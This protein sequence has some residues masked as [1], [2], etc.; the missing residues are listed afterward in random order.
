M[1][2]ALLAAVMVACTQGPKEEAPKA[3]T[4]SPPQSEH[5][6]GTQ[7][8]SLSTAQTPVLVRT[9]ATQTALADGRVLLAGGTTHGSPGGTRQA[10]LFTY[11]SPS[12]TWTAT[13]QM[14]VG[15]YDHAA[16]RLQ[17]GRVLVSGGITAN[18]DW[19]SAELFT[20]TSGQW[21]PVASMGTARARH[22]Q[23]LLANGKVL[24]IGGDNPTTAQ[25]LASAELFDP[26]TG[27]WTATAAPSFAYSSHS[28]TLLPDGRVLVLGNRK[29][30]EL[31]N[32]STNTW[33]RTANSP[34]TLSAGHTATVRASPNV[35]VVV[36]GANWNNGG[37]VPLA[38]RYLPGNNV[39]FT[40]SNPSVARKGHQAVML[41]NG[42]VRIVG[43]V[44]PTQGTPIATV[45]R[46]NTNGNW[47][48]EPQLGQPRQDVRATL[49]G[50]SD[51]MLA[52]GGWTAPTD[53]G[54]P[55]RLAPELYSGCAAKTVCAVG[56]CGNIPDTCGGSL[57]CGENCAS[58]EI[59]NWATNQCQSQCPATNPCAQGRCGI[60]PADTCGS[61]TVDC[62]TCPTQCPL[63]K[64][65]CC[66]GCYEDSQCNLMC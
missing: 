19:T 10:E 44:H 40:M 57:D 51:P 33:A 65:N 7:Q 54:T 39:W 32:P 17:D 41:G 24:V 42:A 30:H 28:A 62:G 56:Q 36:V 26:A 27:T 6:L 38:Y 4:S 53:G 18:G 1:V 29:E 47:Y 3:A 12:T 61:T 52:S 31:Y 22:T 34:V 5:V 55:A 60:Q 13:G 14:N 15:R 2:A 49:V 25:G 64:V 45:E 43:G 58:G 63:G 23:T 11:A 48:T 20:P 59:C 35:E 21:T 8:A 66:G 16:T 9:S 50:T 37:P 46:Y